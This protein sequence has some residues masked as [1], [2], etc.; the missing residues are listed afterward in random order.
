MLSLNA[1][2][3][4]TDTEMW[5]G[6]LSAASRAAEKALLAESEEYNKVQLEIHVVWGLIDEYSGLQSKSS[7]ERKPQSQH[8]FEF[9]AHFCLSPP[10]LRLTLCW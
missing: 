6:L 10:W 8:C 4:G 1:A 7:F 5:P 2:K 9:P 3:P